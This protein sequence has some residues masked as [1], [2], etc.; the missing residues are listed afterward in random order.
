[1]MIDKKTLDALL[2]LPD[3]K[4]MQML[5]IAVGGDIPIKDVSPSTVAGLRDVLGKVTN[6]DISRAIELL[7]IYKNGKRP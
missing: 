2:N 4:L 6:E 3:D 1:M 5:K 7:S